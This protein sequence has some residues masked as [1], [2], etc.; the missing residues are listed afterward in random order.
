MPVGSGPGFP[1]VTATREWESAGEE[2]FALSRAGRIH[3]EARFNNRTLTFWRD[4]DLQPNQ[5]TTILLP[6]VS[7]TL[8]GAM[9]SYDG[10]LIRSD[11]GFAGPRMQLIADDPA[12]WSVTE[13]LPE[14]DAREGEAR[15]RFTLSGLPAGNY[16]LYQHLVGKQQTYSYAGRTTE[17]THP[18]AAWGGIPVKLEANRTTQ[19][20]DFIGYPLND[21]QVCVNDPGGNPVEHAT[22]RI[23]DRMSDSWRQVE[24]NPAQ[25]EQ[26]AYPIPYPAAARI[27][28]GMATLPRIRE[29]WLELVVETD[30]GAIF[31][32]TVPVSA[33]RELRL[34][35][36]LQT[37][38]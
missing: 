33:G 28:A 4:I 29:G 5:S 16:H 9:R 20:P 27:V 11:H 30:A 21:L 31:S 25:L 24:E 6:Q 15:H 17:N 19:L 12:C 35:L 3:V 1:E 34:T 2:T 26:A 10:G 13:Y 22:V 37:E 7:A 14:R 23:R 36:P 8:K 18:I 32:F 38:H